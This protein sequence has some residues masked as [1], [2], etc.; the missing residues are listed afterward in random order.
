[1]VGQQFERT[2]PGSS[3]ISL[4]VFCFLLMQDVVCYFHH[5]TLGYLFYS[6]LFVKQVKHAALRAHHVEYL[7]LIYRWPI[8]TG[9]VHPVVKKPLITWCKE[10]HTLSSLLSVQPLYDWSPSRLLASRHLLSCNEASPPQPL[11]RL[12]RRRSHTVGA[13]MVGTIH[14]PKRREINVFVSPLHNCNLK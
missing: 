5:L 6:A 8:R 2:R 3:T 13:L 9:S 11:S 7:Q 12:L 1:M 4:V 14:P 10:K